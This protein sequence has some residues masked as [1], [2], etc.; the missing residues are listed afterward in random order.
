[1]QG[2]RKRREVNMKRELE[3]FRIGGSWGGNQSWFFDF[4]M[5][6]GGCGAVTAAIAVFI[7]PGIAGWKICIRQMHGR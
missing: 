6:I 1:M 4:M 3:Y 5:R 2:A 7:S